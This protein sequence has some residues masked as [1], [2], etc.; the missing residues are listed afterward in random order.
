[1]SWP[2]ESRNLDMNVM[3]LL[4]TSLATYMYMQQVVFYRYV[5][6]YADIGAPVHHDRGLANIR[7][8]PGIE[9]S[10]LLQV[11]L[12]M[13]SK[14]IRSEGAAAPANEASDDERGVNL[15]GWTA[16]DERFVHVSLAH[17]ACC[18]IGTSSTP[19]AKWQ[20]LYR[21]TSFMCRY[22]AGP[23]AVLGPRG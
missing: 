2:L 17:G 20:H 10:E 9:R 14:R 23:S 1:M 16:G 4:Y 3:Y 6:S 12:L 13:I 21:R 19:G 18:S 11:R 15:A 8:L 22:H 7:I 5:G